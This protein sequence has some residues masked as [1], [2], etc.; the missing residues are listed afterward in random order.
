MKKSL[1]ALAALAVVG[2]AS[3]QSSVTLFGIVDAAVTDVYNSQN[4]PVGSI[5]TSKLWMDN[6][7]YNSSRLGFRG[8][9]DL[10]GGLAASFWLEAALGNDDGTAGGGNGKFA[11]G[12]G[13]NQFFNRRSTVSLSGGFGEIRIGRDYVPTFWD[14]TVYDPF[15][16][17]GIGSQLA[18]NAALAFTAYDPITKTNGAH[19]T[20]VRA[21]NSIGYFLPPNLGGIYGQVMYAF[22]ETNSYDASLANQ[23][24]QTTFGGPVNQNVGR[25]FGGRIG[26]ANGP[27]DVAASYGSETSG[28]AGAAPWAAATVVG[29]PGKIN[30]WNIGGT[31]DFGAAK[32][33]A[34]YQQTKLSL[35]DAATAAGINTQYQTGFKAWLLGVTVP[36]GSGYVRASYGAVKYDQNLASLL[37][38]KANQ[39]ALGYVYDMSK[40]TSLYATF[41]RLANKEGSTLQ[42]ASNNGGPG[43]LVNN[44]LSSSSTGYQFGIKHS[45]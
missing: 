35:D 39:F 33:W 13:S 16:T 27:I 4:L 44:G 30:S 42:L 25:Y 6:S 38:P 26:Y 28:S 34:D 12:S 11:S 18:F 14:D 3:A 29:H 41:A 17:N 1:V 32:L 15:G 22:P 36:V 43:G 24:T 37:T 31:Y 8:T 2:A 7:G 10:G 20:Y 9:E 23:T 21:N 19:S 5:K 45:F 40:R